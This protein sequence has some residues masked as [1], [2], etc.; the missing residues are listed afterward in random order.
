L[1]LAIFFLHHTPNF[2]AAKLAVNQGGI[3]SAEGNWREN[4]FKIRKVRIAIK[5]ALHDDDELSEQVFSE[6][7]GLLAKTIHRLLTSHPRSGNLRPSTDTT[8]P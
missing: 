1:A 7:T 2:A 6:A 5:K 8:L 4:I 3:S